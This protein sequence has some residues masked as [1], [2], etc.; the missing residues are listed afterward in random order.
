MPLLRRPIPRIFLTLLAFLVSAR[1]SPRDGP[2]CY[3]EMGWVETYLNQPD[4]K[5]QLGIAP[6]LDFQSCNMQV[7]QVSARLCSPPSGFLSN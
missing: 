6:S 2:L 4:V 3:K 7:N 5:R 1:A